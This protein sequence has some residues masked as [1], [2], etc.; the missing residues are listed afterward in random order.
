MTLERPGSWKN[1]MNALIVSLMKMDWLNH[2]KAKVLED[3]PRAVVGALMVAQSL[4]LLGWG[5]ST[6]ISLYSRDAKLVTQHPPP[7]RADDLSFLQAINPET[8][9]LKG[10]NPFYAVP[11]APPTVHVTKPRPPSRPAPS[12]PPPK[13]PVFR[14]IDLVYKGMMLGADGKAL[15]L[16]QDK[17]SG[18][19]LFLKIGDSVQGGSVSSFNANALVWEKSGTRIELKLGQNQTVGQIQIP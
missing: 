7:A 16:V 18:Q 19:S 2:W 12:S 1:Q 11:Q 14:N 15:A 9:V 8:F 4:V 10:N 3:K 6:G 5:V 17:T 13:A